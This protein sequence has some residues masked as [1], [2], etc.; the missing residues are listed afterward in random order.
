MKT[1][2]KGRLAGS[3]PMNTGMKERQNVGAKDTIGEPNRMGDMDARNLADAIEMIRALSHLHRSLDD[4]KVALEAMV[5]AAGR[6]ID[7]ALSHWA[8]LTH[9]LVPQVCRQ[10]DLKAQ[11]NLASP[12]LSR[13]IESLVVRGFISRYQHPKDRRQYLLALTPE[14]RGVCMRMLLSITGTIDRGWLCQ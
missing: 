10:I 6:P 11:T 1:V 2:P 3:L 8:I 5:R 9:L 12:H 4:A 14:G 7:L 13:L